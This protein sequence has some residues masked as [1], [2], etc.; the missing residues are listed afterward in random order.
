VATDAHIDSYIWSNKEIEEQG[1]V[2]AYIEQ[3][4]QSLN[5]KNYAMVGPSNYKA[6]NLI[7]LKT[8]FEFAQAD[9]G[10]RL[11]DFLKALH[12]TPS[13]GG[14]PK[15]AA[16]EFILKNEKHDRA[17][18]TGFLGPVNIE[19]ESNV[20]V[21]LRCLQLFD[22]QFVLY[23]GAGITASSDAEKEW[24]ETNN[25]MMTMLNVMNNL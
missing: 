7:H 20:F 11:G 5:I 25:K 9:L 2:T 3:T 21:N 1:I 4:L 23:S 19:G 16:R 22:K 15:E 13:V 6:A 10:K 14:L 18:Y 24:E 8:G 17:Y 12:P